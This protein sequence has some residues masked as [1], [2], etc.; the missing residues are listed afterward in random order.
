[1]YPLPKKIENAFLDSSNLVVEVN[2]NQ[3]D[4]IELSKKLV[5]PPGDSLQKHISKETYDKIMEM[6]SKYMIPKS[7]INMQ[8]PGA[9]A[10][11]LVM[12]KLLEMGYDPEYG[13]DQYFLKKAHKNKKNILELESI[14]EQLSLIDELDEQCA[15]DNLVMGQPVNKEVNMGRYSPFC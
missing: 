8:K 9:V 15:M 4:P 12:Y 7:A 14:D 3:L 6:F 11:S 5:Y 2:I 1:M 10:M 13:I